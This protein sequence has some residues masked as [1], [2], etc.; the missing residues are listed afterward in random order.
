MTR[1]VI[2]GG[3]DLMI[4]PKWLSLASRTLGFS[5]AVEA[6]HHSGWWVAVDREMVAYTYELQLGRLKFT[7]SRKLSASAA[8]HLVEQA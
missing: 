7:L 5:V 2:V 6:P 3:M 4:A 8:G 1:T